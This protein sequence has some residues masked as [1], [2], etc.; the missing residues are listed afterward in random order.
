MK[1]TPRAHQSDVMPVAGWQSRHG[2]GAMTEET[3]HREVVKH[4]TVRATAG[5]IWWHTPN[6]D[7]RHAGVA[8]RLKAMGTKPGIPDL[9][10]Y[11]AS[12]LYG[13]E[14]KRVGGRV[15][16]HQRLRQNELAAAGAIIATVAGLDGAINTLR[17]WGLIR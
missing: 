16:E 11:R 5:T 13:L 14:L 17:G 3:I 1:T 4:L 10:L 2:A 12:Q 6:G 8:G 15:S 7:K 9:L